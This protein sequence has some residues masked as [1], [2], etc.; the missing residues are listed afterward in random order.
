M[1]LE[2]FNYQLP[3]SL[4][5]AFP[6]RER[7]G[8]RLLVIRRA[9]GEIIHSGFAELGNFLDAGDLL[10]LNDTQVFPARLLG[11]KDSGGKVE[12]LLLER[13]P[14][15]GRIFWL[16]L[17]D[18]AKKV[19]VGSLLHFGPSMSAEVIGDMG[20]GRFGLEF[21]HCG[22]FSAQLEALGEPPLPPYVRRT[23][24]AE[25]LD[26]ERYQTVYATHPGAIAAPTAGFHFT[27]ELFAKLSAQG[28]DRALLTL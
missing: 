7:E 9:T 15:E 23:R 26:R 24:E 21:Q 1:N 8:S 20:R 25:A 27:P 13:F 4:I 17:I 11:S 10:V 3:E 2:E 6:S 18:S 16:A 22:D 5:A 28:I 14:D 19:R 12:V